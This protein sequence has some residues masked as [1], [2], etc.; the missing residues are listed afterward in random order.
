MKPQEWFWYDPRFEINAGTYD[1]VNFMAA[2]V[3]KQNGVKKRDIPKPLVRP[4]QK[5]KEEEKIVG[6]KMQLDE[7]RKALGWS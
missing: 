4:W 7:M 3:A 6:D 5:V 1:A 2:T